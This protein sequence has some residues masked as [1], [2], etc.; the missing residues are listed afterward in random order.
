VYSRSMQDHTPDL[1][2]HR[3]HAHLFTACVL[4]ISYVVSHALPLMPSCSTA[5]CIACMGISIKNFGE[6]QHNEMHAETIET[7]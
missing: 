7:R 3:Y 4:L 6:V 5:V 1:T 2:L